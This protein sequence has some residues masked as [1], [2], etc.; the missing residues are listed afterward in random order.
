MFTVL[1]FLTPALWLAAYAFWSLR[2]HKPKEVVFRINVLLLAVILGVVVID[3]V[4]RFLRK[5]RYIE[6]QV[7]H[8][9]NWPGARVDDIVR[10]RPPD[11]LYKIR[12]SDTPPTAR[13]YPSPPPGYPTVDVIL[14]TDGRGYRNLTRLEQYDIMT[15]GDSFT[16]GS[17]VSDDEAWPVL[18]GRKLNQ[19]VYNLGISGGHPDYYLNAFEAFG[20][21]LKPKTAVFMIYGGNDFKESQSGRRSAKPLGERMRDT[22][23]ASPVVLG[24]KRAFIRYLGPINADVPVPGANILS[25]MPVAVRPGPDAKYYSFKPKRLVRLYWT[26]KAFRESEGWISTAQIFRKIKALCAGE[27]IRLIFAYAPSKP[28]VVMPLVKE[29]VTAEQLHTFASFT[30]RGLPPPEEFKRELYTRLDNQETVLREFFEKEGIEFVT[31]T[32]T[33][34]KTAAEGRQVYY[35]YDQHWTALGQA[36]VAEKLSRYFS[37]GYTGKETK[38][39]FPADAP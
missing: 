29:R 7:V 12:Y 8:Q 19:T 11:Q 10:H 1:F 17:R 14:T 37:E 24:L 13:S 22:V 32:E 35:T 38:K 6:R 33:I 34:R 5:P 21:A 25:W 2:T 28:Q 36:A 26:K 31:T 20:L 23:K 18:L 30:K 39:I 3:V 16:E 4:G 15:V 9:V 27:G